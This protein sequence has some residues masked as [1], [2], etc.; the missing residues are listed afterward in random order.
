MFYAEVCGGCGGSKIGNLFCT[1][2]LKVTT[3]DG[4]K[5]TKVWASVMVPEGVGWD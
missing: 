4:L 2:G 5:A 3:S 1:K